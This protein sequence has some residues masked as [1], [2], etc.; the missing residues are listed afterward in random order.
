MG[1][2]TRSADTLS[3]YLRSCIQER[4]RLAG[5]TQAAMGRRLGVTQSSVSYVVSGT[6]RPEPLE[7]FER[8]AALF[9]LTLSELLREAE[10]R[11]A[12][13]T[14]DPVRLSRRKTVVNSQAACTSE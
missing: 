14:A 8:I 13:T 7:L 1:S 9:G 5:V 6:R 12:I 2:P 11:R 4:M 10:V 3:R